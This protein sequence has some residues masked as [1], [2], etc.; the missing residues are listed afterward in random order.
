MKKALV[1]GITGQDG[2]YLAELLLQKGYEV[3]GTIRRSSDFNTRRID[4]I[5]NPDSR[6]NIHFADLATGLDNLI[7]KIK[8]DEIY[9]L[10]SM[11]HVKVS[12]EVPVYT[13]DVT[14]LAVCRILEAIREGINSGILNPKIKF[15]QA[16]S[17]E[18][19]GQTPTPIGGYSENDQMTPVSPYGCA[20]LYGYHI[21]KTYRTGF[22]MFAA[23]GILFNHESPRRGPTFVTRKITRAAA[24]IKLGLQDKLVLGNLDALR[25]WGH[26]RDYMKAICLIMEQDK[27]DDYV[28]ATGDQYSVRHFMEAVFEYM[29]LDWKKYV[30]TD[31]CMLRPNEVPNLLGD[32]TKIRLLGWKPEYDFNKLVAEM[33]EY[34]LLVEGK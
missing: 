33:C 26:S 34:D 32:S 20:K 4:H 31:K 14:G 6:T 12:F 30:I 1:T 2:S 7:Y 11:S 13:G 29:K 25:D 21:T 19:F 5:F 3:H 9:N 17:S 28:V 15:Y 10:G 24:K 23:N 27:P 16:S 8:P 18:M 22:N